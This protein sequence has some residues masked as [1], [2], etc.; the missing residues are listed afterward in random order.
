[1]VHAE[2]PSLR[3]GTVRQGM[4]CRERGDH[5]R[6]TFP[7]HC[8]VS[9]V[10]ENRDRI[11]VRHPPTASATQD[12]RFV[13]GWRH[14]SSRTH[15]AP[16]QCIGERQSIAETQRPCPLCAPY[17]DRLP[18]PKIQGARADLAV[19]ACVAF[20]VRA[21]PSRGRQFVGSVNPTEDIMTLVR[22]SNAAGPWTETSKG[23]RTRVR[24]FLAQANHPRYWQ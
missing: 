23:R 3:P 15:G 1:M 17:T 22:W 12:G 20:P 10:P 9:T 14:P 18:R 11:P 7:S 8:P 4:R 6:S 5:P 19:L 24:G 2:K 13:W 21:R 16:E